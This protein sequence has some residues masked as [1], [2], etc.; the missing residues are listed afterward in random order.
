MRT[1]IMGQEKVDG[2]LSEKQALFLR[3]FAALW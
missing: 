3:A 1:R 2:F